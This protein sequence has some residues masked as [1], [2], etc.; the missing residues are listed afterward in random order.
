M[1]TSRLSSD[2]QSSRSA[3]PFAGGGDGQLVHDAAGHAGELVLGLLRQPG[4]A[5]RIPRQI[6]DGAEG[7]SDGNLERRRRGQ[8]GAGRHLARDREVR[9]TE[10]VARPEH[11]PRD[12]GDVAEP[13]AA[14]TAPVGL[15][16]G[17]ALQVVERQLARLAELGGVGAQHAI[18]ARNKGDGD[19]A[20]N[21]HRQDET[22]VVVGVL[23]DQVDPA[24][25]D[26]DARAHAA[27]RRPAR[28][29]AARGE[30]DV[31]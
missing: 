21:R 19:V 18:L 9:A 10:R 5:P 14:G 26:R 22:V 27:A 29:R 23:A 2:R 17:A 1:G 13:S 6:G 4:R 24:G 31:G 20:I 3:H 15:G 16:R 7:P 11:R 8:P 28:I 12:A 30:E 25:R